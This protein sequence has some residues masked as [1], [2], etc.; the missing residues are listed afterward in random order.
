MRNAELGEIASRSQLRWSFL[1]WA[2]VTVPFVVLLGFASGQLVPS[3]D[4]NSW[5]AALV[6]P[7]GTP[8]GW[9]FPVVWTSLYVM[10]GLALAMILNA[11]GSR[12]SLAVILFMV[13]LV[14]N[15]SWTPVFFG[16]GKI[17]LAMW[18]IVAMLALSI[19]VT[20]LFARIRKPAAWLMVPYM[21]WIS[22]AGCLTWGIGQ[23]NPNAEGL[24]RP[25]ASTQIQL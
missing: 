9:V 25:A 10:L 1:R 3:G 21:V 20:V 16:A 5:Y 8:P 7:V 17:Q 23:L 19:A 24:A 13:Q 2:F 18:I 12:R 11:R 22:Y 15:L 14:L 6:K 4:A